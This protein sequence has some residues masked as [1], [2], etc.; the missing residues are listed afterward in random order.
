M[1]HPPATLGPQAVRTSPLAWIALALTFVS[2]LPLGLVLGILDGVLD[3]VCTLAGASL[4]VVVLLR[5]RHGIDHGRLV[6]WIAL[7]SAAVHLVFTLALGLITVRIF[8]D[9]DPGGDAEWASPPRGLVQGDCLHSELRPVPTSCEEPHRA[10][11]VDT[12]SIPNGG[13]FDVPEDDADALCGSAVAEYLGITEEEAAWRYGFSISGE[14]PYEV[15][16]WAVSDESV[17]GT[18]RATRP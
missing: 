14:R 7:I 5:S 11:V 17:T 8:D 4:A 18:M 2:V 6:A 9:M 3:L 12:F 1:D 15:S 13:W 16:C 10:E